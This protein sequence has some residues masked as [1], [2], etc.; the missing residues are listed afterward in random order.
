MEHKS[1]QM[2]EKGFRMKKNGEIYYDGILWDPHADTKSKKAME[3]LAVALNCNRDYF[4][5]I[6]KETGRWMIIKIHL[7]LQHLLMD[8]VIK[9]IGPEFN[10]IHEWN[11]KEICDLASH[12]LFRK[13]KILNFQRKKFLLDLNTLRNAFIH[14]PKHHEFKDLNKKGIGAAKKIFTENLEKEM[15]Y[16][17]K[18]YYSKLKFAWL[19]HSTLTIGLILSDLNDLQNFGEIMEIADTF[20][21]SNSF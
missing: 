14:Y 17:N 9:E 11:F 8:V 15:Y 13:N 3:I 5:S 21:G 7:I 20:S 12:L 4:E 1:F 18:D 16:D 2:K 10:S 19:N 6:R